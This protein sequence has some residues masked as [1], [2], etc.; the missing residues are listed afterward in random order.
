MYTSEIFEK[1]VEVEITKK[2]GSKVYE[3]AY[4]QHDFF[5][6]LKYHDGNSIKAVNK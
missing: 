6:F 4:S 5:V 3:I 1:P 2:D